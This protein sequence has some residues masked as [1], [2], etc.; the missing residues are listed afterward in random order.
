MPVVSVV[1]PTYKRVDYLGRMIESVMAQTFEDWELIIVDGRSDDGTAALVGRYQVAL[2]DRLVFIEEDNQGCCHAR[3]TGIDAARGAFVALLDSDDEFLPTKLER[4]LELFHLRPELGLVYSDYA[5]ITLDGAYHRSVFDTKGK[6]AR[7]VPI[8]TVAPGLCVC[9]PDFFDY[10]IRQYFI[11]TIVGLVRRE[12]LADDIRFLENDLYGGEW[13]FYLEIARRAR[14]G[15]VD[16]P[17]CLHHWVDGSLSRT[18]KTRNMIYHR[19]LMKVM[20]RRFSDASPAAK[21]EMRTQLEYDCL[22]LGMQSYKQ[23]EYGPAVRYFGERRC[24]N[25]HGCPPRSISHSRPVAGPPVSADRDTSQFSGSI[26][27]ES[28]PKRKHAAPMVPCPSEPRSALQTR[29][30]GP[31]SPPITCTMF[32]GSTEHECRVPHP[33]SAAWGGGLKET[34]RRSGFVSPPPRP[35]ERDGAPSRPRRQAMCG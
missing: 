12:V 21:A 24:D 26:P 13:L 8:E 6:L 3:N 16:E 22:H 4:Q 27:I 25:T 18:N 34:E 30:A 31:Q 1:V 19:R 29:C 23:A 9:P 11:A 35:S 20:Q 15:Y 7:T 5:Y 14:V 10:L 2:G 32:V 33:I 17:L 28:Y